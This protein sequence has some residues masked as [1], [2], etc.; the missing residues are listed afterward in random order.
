MNASIFQLIA[1][2]AS[3]VLATATQVQ[4]LALGTLQHYLDLAVAHPDLAS[5]DDKTAPILN[6]REQSGM[7]KIFADIE[8]H[9]QLG[10][11]LR[12][13]A[14]YEGMDVPEDGLSASEAD[15]PR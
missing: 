7:P 1:V 9:H 8:D 13:N 10:D 3:V 2:L 5:C 14:S 6:G 12:T 4:F 11:G 15:V